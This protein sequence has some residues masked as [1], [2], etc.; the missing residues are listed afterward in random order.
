MKNK[1]CVLVAVLAALG[2]LFTAGTMEVKTEE[3][4]FLSAFHLSCWFE[5]Q[6]RW[7]VS[8]KP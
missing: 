7:T 4:A 6:L 5:A 1:L 3:E 2:L 8:S